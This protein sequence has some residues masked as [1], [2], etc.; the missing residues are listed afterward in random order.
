MKAESDTSE[1]QGA[2]D[3]WAYE[4]GGR[5]EGEQSNCSKRVVAFVLL[6]AADGRAE[7]DD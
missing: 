3:D 5:R 1:S 6:L 7:V 2:K 4:Q